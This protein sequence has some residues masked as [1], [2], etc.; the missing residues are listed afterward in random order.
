MAVEAFKALT[1]FM[2]EKAQAIESFK[3]SEEFYDVKI[4]FSQEA[5][6]MGHKARYKDCHHRVAA[7][8]PEADLSLDEDEGEEEVE[9]E[10]ILLRLILLR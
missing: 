1:D 9:G 3:V 8:L 4:V 5:F 7:W 2:W 6:N 10:P